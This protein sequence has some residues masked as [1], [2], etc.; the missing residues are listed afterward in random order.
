MIRRTARW[1]ARHPIWVLVGVALVTAFFGTFAPRIEFLTDMEKML[2]Q[3]NPVV[4]R[5]EETKDTFGSQSM[6]MVAMAAPEG[7]TVFNLET[8]KKLYAITDEFEKLEDDKLLE[9]VMSPANMDIVQGTA[10]ALVVGPIL[11]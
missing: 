8:L 9:D 11:P 5:F 3:D 6:V 4:R 1:I 7:G 2:P 10:T